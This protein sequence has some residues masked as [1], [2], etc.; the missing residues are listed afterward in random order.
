MTY[1][2]ERLC[3][4]VQGKKMVYLDLIDEGVKYKEAQ[5]EKNFSTK[6]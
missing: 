6:I 1:G 5:A 4:F 3:M 2:L